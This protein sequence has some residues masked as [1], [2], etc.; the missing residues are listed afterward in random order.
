MQRIY[1]FFKKIAS[2]ELAQEIFDDKEDKNKNYSYSKSEYSHSTNSKKEIASE[3]PFRLLVQRIHRKYM[4]Q[5]L[6]S[7]DKVQKEKGLK[8]I[9]VRVYAI[10]RDYLAFFARY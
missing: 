8:I 7:K 5:G 3:M 2:G 6:K 1:E 9:K 4:I 10:C